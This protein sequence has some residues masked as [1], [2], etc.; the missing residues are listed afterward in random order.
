MKK[1]LKFES[2]RL[3]NKK[4]IILLPLILIAIGLAGIMLGSA[5]NNDFSPKICMLNV[6]NAYS[7]FAFLFLSFIYISILAEDFSKGYYKFYKQIGFSL[8]E[9]MV[10]KSILLY[11]IT[12]LITDAFMFIY[13]IIVNVSDFGF[14]GLMILSVDLGLLFILLLSN[15]LALIFKKTTIATVVSFVLYIAFDFTNLVAYGLT[16]PCDANSLACVTF[17]QLA[18]LKLTHESLSK[19][20]L[21]YV[22]NSLIYTTGP[23]L[24]Y[25]LILII[26]IYILIKKEKRSI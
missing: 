15:V 26:I 5:Y 22:G 6:Y 11:A 21:N 25:I 18:G 13:S 2:K 24:V 1:L 4:T 10:T 3:C 14:V 19:L 23:A 16:N 8:I 7:Q 20:G 9:C 17:G 12:I